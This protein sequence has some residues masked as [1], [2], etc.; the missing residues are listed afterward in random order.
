M[1]GSRWEAL[2][3][4]SAAGRPQWDTCRIVALSPAVRPFLM[5]MIS[6][7]G[8]PPSAPSADAS[9]S[10]RYAAHLGAIRRLASQL[11]HSGAPD[12]LARVLVEELQRTVGAAWVALYRADP[13]GSFSRRAL[14]GDPGGRLPV[15]ISGGDAVALRLPTTPPEERAVS[16]D[17]LTV[18]GGAAIA[19]PLE[20]A[21]K[22]LGWLVSGQRLDGVPFDA[23]DTELITLMCDI[24]V[25]RLAAAEFDAQFAR[26]A[27]TDQL[28]GLGN[29]RAF[30]ERLEEEIARANRGGTALSLLLVD[31]DKFA[32]FN[33]THGRDA[34]DRALG[35][36]AAAVRSCIRLSDSAFRYGGGQLA[37]LLPGAAALGAFVAAERIR[38]SVA[39]LD[40]PDVPAPITVSIGIGSLR[41]GSHAPIS[42][43]SLALVRKADEALYQAKQSGRN[44]TV[45]G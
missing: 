3:V 18:F 37:L 30:N 28:T 11:A 45:I 33:A 6:K 35:A 42:L 1:F 23:V 10:Q 15:T 4:V 17:A 32:G 29:R 36:V 2:D 14:A 43:A 40:A 13:A 8:A 9:A 41:E 7:P 24:A 38:N 26:S 31:V 27:L 12:Q 19:I 25:P 39:A 21:E 44:R 22:R 20:D 34:G 5:K 16:G